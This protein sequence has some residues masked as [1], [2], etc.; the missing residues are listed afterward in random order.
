MDLHLQVCRN[1]LDGRRFDRIALG[2][3]YSSSRRFEL[4]DGFVIRFAAQCRIRFWKPMKG[5]FLST[6]M[7]AMCVSAFVINFDEAPIRI[8]LS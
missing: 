7:R 3:D 8:I 5:C 6:Q 2:R 1:G 4:S